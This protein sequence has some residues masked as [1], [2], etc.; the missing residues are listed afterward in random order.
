VRDGGDGVRA[1]PPDRWEPAGADAPEIADVLARAGGWGGDL[2]DL[3]G[4]DAAPG[5]SPA[6]ARPAA[7]PVLALRA[8]GERTPLF[9]FHPAG[10]PAGVYRPLAAL[11]GPDQPVYGLER[12]PDVRTVAGKAARYAEL[13]R[14][15]QPDGPYRLGGWSFG[16]LLAFETARQLA[17]AGETVQT[18]ALIDAIL[19]LPETASSAE[20]AVRRRFQWLAEQVR[21]AYGYS[22]R[23]HYDE[24]ARLDEDSQLDL[25]LQTMRGGLGLSPAMLARQRASQE[26]LRIGERYEPRRHD[27]P[28]VLFRA[29]DP[30]PPAVRDPRYE[31]TDPALGWDLFCA[32]LRVVPVRGHHLSLLDPPAVDTIAEELTALLHRSP[33]RA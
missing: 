33:G 16:G 2:P 19:P 8:E 10:G 25:V 6:G 22:L 4:F 27:G 5:T 14:G 30:A 13:V 24:L 17:A 28:V 31:R 18:V 21:D 7:A 29:T 12:L 1:V 9:L 3:T 23:L 26:D 20:E 11:L 32:E 15:V